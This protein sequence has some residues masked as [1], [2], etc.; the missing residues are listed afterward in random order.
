MNIVYVG[1]LWNGST[2]L[3]RMRCFKDLGHKIYPI[4]TMPLVIHKRIHKIY[5]KIVFKLFRYADLV[6]ANTSIIKKVKNNYV[7]VLWIDKGVTIAAKTLIKV[8]K[9][10]SNI[11]IAGYSPDDMGSSHNQTARFISS[12]SNYDVYFT[13]KSYGVSDI[14]QLGCNNVNF[15]GNAYDSNTH[16]PYNLTQ[17]EKT[18][19]GCEVGFVGEY[20][21]ERANSIKFIADNGIRVRI[22]GPNWQKMEPHDNIKIETTAVWGEDYAKAICAFD[23]ALC[24]LRKIN[25]DLQ[26]QRSIEIPACGSF[27]L[28]ERTNEHLELFQEDVE[29]VYFS[30]NSELLEKCRYYLQHDEEREKIAS[31]GRN[32]CVV[33]GYS[34]ISRIQKMVEIVQN[35]KGKLEK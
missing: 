15:I 29:A 8:K 18:T 19:F 24:F 17:E 31:A 11:I 10:N 23:I 3:Q 2:C 20:E 22:F 1:P 6:G 12:L 13:T 16:K 34:N 14:M 25:R 7:D 32:R 35:I 5:F 9:I 33:G 27:M 4:D 21:L 28:A 26:T 30:D